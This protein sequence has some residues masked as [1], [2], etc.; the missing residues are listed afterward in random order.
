M[1]QILH[2]S[3]SRDSIYMHSLSLRVEVLIFRLI[4][5]H[6]QFQVKLKNP[7]SFRNFHNKLL[8]VYSSRLKDVDSCVVAQISLHCSKFLLDFQ[9][10]RSFIHLSCNTHRMPPILQTQILYVCDPYDAS[11]LCR[12]S[13]NKRNPCSSLHPLCITSFRL[14]AW[15]NVDLITD[16]S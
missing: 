11:M 5:I 13:I 6:F 8:C 16:V 4:K 9:I 12:V 15:C 10:S 14:I 3:Y 2:N 7:T 1:S